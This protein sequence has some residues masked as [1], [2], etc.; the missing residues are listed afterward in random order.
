[1]DATETSGKQAELPDYQAV[2]TAAKRI[3]PW[4]NQTPV[5]RSASL[6][7]I[8]GTKLYFKCENFQK[9]GAFKARGAC[10][11][12]F[13]LPEDQLK[14]G[15]ATHSSGNHGAAL[16]RA[17][18]LR[19]APAWVV[20]PHNANR[21]KRAAVEAWGANI[22]DCEASM[23]SRLAVLEKIVSETG[24][25]V[26]P[27]FHDARIIAGQGTAALELLAEHP[28]LDSII[29]PV[30]GGGLLAGSA[31][32][33]HG[34]NPAIDVFGAEPSGNADAQQ[35]FQ[36]GKVIAIEQPD[37]IADGLRGTIGE[38]PLAVIKQHVRAIVTVDDAAIIRA[39]RLIWERLK[40]VVEPSAAIALAVMLEKRLDV[41]GNKVGIILSGGNVDLDNLSI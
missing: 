20:M 18:K 34:C 12:V 31:L 11:A 16:A 9:T 32:A 3:A 6:D 10:N 7:T 35:S 38:L 14:A 21:A 1:M 25:H 24:A 2:C 29:T 28:D 37:T 33:A 26:V 22:V 36:A 19:N 15:V 30:G 17:A 40:I 4:I 27:P 5:M 8:A 39:M 13:S 23:A 41:A